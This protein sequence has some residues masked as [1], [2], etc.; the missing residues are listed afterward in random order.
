MCIGN[1]GIMIR[2]PNEKKRGR[3]VSCSMATFSEFINDHELVDPPLAGRRFTWTKYE[4]H[5]KRC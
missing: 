2:Y 3:Y 1:D 5:V 4:F